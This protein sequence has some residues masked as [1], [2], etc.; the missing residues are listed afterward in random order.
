MSSTRRAK[1]RVRI[2][3]VV[4]THADLVD[5]DNGDDISIPLLTLPPNAF[6]LNVDLEVVTQFSGGSIAT[7]T[8]DVGRSTD[9]DSVIS[10]FDALSVAGRYAGAAGVHPRGNYSEE[11]L[12]ANFDPDASHNLTG[13]TAGEMKIHV[14]YCQPDGLP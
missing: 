9:T 8:L 14:L 10:N 12:V 7:L 11:A 13:L 1:A 2:A 6:L 4:I 3:T 5:A